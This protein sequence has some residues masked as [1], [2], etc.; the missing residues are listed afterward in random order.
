VLW[1]QIDLMEANKHA[2]HTMQ[3]VGNGDAAGGVGIGGVGIK[4]AFGASEYGP[5]ASQIDTNLPFR[6]YTTTAHT[7]HALSPT[8]SDHELTLIL[9]HATRGGGPHGPRSSVRSISVL[10]THSHSISALFS[11]RLMD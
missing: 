4:W 5:G 9:R 11:L 2:W 8:S 1:S 6:V 10:S 7:T 3:H